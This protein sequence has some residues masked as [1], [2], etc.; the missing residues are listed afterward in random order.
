MKFIPILP[1]LIVAISFCLFNCSEKD[2]PE[3]IDIPCADIPCGIDR[4]VWDEPANRVASD[5]QFRIGTWLNIKK[6]KGSQDTI[7]FH[8][9]E[10]WSRRNSPI[11][12][13][14]EPYKFDH[15]YLESRHL[16]YIFP[17]PGIHVDLTLYNDTTGVFSILYKD[18]LNK[19]QFWD[20]Y[21]KIQ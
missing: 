8:D 11:D 3:I 6:Y 5:P 14:K 21:I 10:Y 9:E 15:M 20:H 16:S 1:L 2:E 4:S 13:E 12:F 17:K 19:D 18:G 7:I